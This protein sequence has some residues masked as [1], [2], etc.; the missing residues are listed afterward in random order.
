MGLLLNRA[1]NNNILVQNGFEKTKSS[2]TGFLSDCYEI[3]IPIRNYYAWIS[4]KPETG[5]FFVYVEY[6]CGGE[7]NRYADHI[8]ID[9]ESDPEVFFNQLDEKVSYFLEC[10]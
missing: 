6:H 3:A 8:D 5:D 7:V 1:D 9:F 4:V 2:V 10:V